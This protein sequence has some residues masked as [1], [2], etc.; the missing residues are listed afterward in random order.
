MFFFIYFFM[1]AVVAIAVGNEI[2]REKMGQT[3]RPVRISYSNTKSYAS[4]LQ[5]S[6]IVMK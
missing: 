3:K 1:V 5:E 2:N 6:T 4:F